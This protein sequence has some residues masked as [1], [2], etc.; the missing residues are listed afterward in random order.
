LN[1]ITQIKVIKYKLFT[2]ETDKP[3]IINM[4]KLFNT[5][6]VNWENGEYIQVEDDLEKDEGEE[7]EEEEEDEDEDD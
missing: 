2:S 3:E 4:N 5:N 7:E 6:K 1:I